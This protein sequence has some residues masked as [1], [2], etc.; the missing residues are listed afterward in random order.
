MATL[1][2]RISKGS[3]LTNQEMDDNLSNLNNEIATKLNSSTYTASDILTKIKTVD[4]SGSGLDADVLDGMAP[5]NANTPSTIVNR[6]AS[7]NFSAGT[8]TANLTGNASGTAAN[9]T[10]IVAIVNGGTGANNAASARLNLGVDASGDS[11]AFAI[12][13]G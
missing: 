2:L 5:T 13:L 11:L 6:D 10:G 12:A 7:G 8:I 3:P 9:V 1:V 4:G